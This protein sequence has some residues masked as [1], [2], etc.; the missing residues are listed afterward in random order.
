MARNFRLW[1]NQ[2]VVSLLAPAADAAGR[3]SSYFSI[4][5]GHKAYIVCHINQGNAATVAL[6][7]LQATNLAGANSKAISVAPIVVDANTAVSDALVVQAAAAGFTTDAGTNNKVVIFEIDPIESMD[8]NNTAVGAFSY[9]AVSTGAS[10]AANITAA[11]LILA[12]LRFAQ[13]TPPTTMV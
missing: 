2:Q 8:L 9:L 5:N 1:E 13:L 10:N 6:T 12:P 7:P 4:K 3:T 11:L